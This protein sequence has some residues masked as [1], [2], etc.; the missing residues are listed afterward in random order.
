M[1]TQHESIING[2]DI[3]ED[4]ER[5]MLAAE[6][7]GMSFEPMIDCPQNNPDVI[8]IL[9]DDDDEDIGD[10]NYEKIVKTED[11]TEIK[12]IDAEAN[13]GPLNTGYRGHKSSPTF[14]K[15]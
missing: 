6:N 9:D 1:L 11:E 10:N 4:Q 3:I 12:M 2:E 14:R 8:E 13:N 5:A 15:N 7:S